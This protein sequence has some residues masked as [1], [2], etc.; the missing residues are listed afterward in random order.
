M[1]A[2]LVALAFAVSAAVLI[3]VPLMALHSNPAFQARSRM[4][5]GSTDADGGSPQTPSA[6]WA[7]AES[8]DA[9]AVETRPVHPNLVGAPSRT[10]GA[11]TG[12]PDSPLSPQSSVGGAMIPAAPPTGFH[13]GDSRG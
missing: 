11:P 8:P 3:G 7:G 2:V 6:R 12:S 1:T 4:P 10:S 9:E 5:G 13:Q